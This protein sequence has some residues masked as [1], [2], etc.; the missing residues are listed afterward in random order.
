VVWE[1]WG[2]FAGAI[3][4]LTRLDG[5]GFPL[6]RADEVSATAVAADAHRVHVRLESTLQA[7]RGSAVQA[8]GI[9]LFG[10][11]TTAVVFSLLNL[12]LPLAIVAGAA[13][14]GAAILS[15]RSSY[16]R[17]ANL[18]QLA[19][20]QILDRLEFGEASKGKLFSL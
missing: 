10:G 11:A 12:M 20:E 7:R 9:G 4:T 15:S 16:R 3:R 14:S 1:P 8:T 17:D 6:A 13:I 19:L 5:R 2:G 18:T